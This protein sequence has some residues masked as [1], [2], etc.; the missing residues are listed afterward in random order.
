MEIIKSALPEPEI[1]IVCGF[2]SDKV[3][4][5]APEECI[6]L[7]NELY[8]VTNVARSVGMA[9]RATKSSRVL[10]LT[11][12]LVFNKEALTTLDYSMSCTSANEDKYKDAEVGCVVD[13][14][15]NL[16]HMMYDLDLK[17][18]QI[19]YL[20]GKEL[21]MFKKEAWDTKHKK[22]FLF[23]ILN[24]VISTGGKIKCIQN[25]LVKTVDVDSSKDIS[26]AK[27]IV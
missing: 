19:V 26:R 7:E 22:Y 16:A 8:E 23:E 3:I 27:E 2:R 15:G 24:R 25:E 20:Q 21:A 17:W 18:N 12:D 14:N 4:S 1:L 13:E 5:K 6:K 9:L 10:V 11:G